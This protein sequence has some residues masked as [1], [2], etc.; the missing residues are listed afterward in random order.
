[1]FSLITKKVTKVRVL[2]FF[3]VLGFLVFVYS[4]RINCWLLPAARPAQNESA[5]DVV[6]IRQRNETKTVKVIRNETKTILVWNGSS[7]REV[8]N[9]GW[10]K[11]AFINKN[12]SY[13]RCEMTDNRLERPLEQFDAIIFVLNDEFTSPDQMMMPDFEKHKRNASQHIVMF[14]QEA[15][16][17]LK[18]YYNMTRLANFFNLSM[19][20]RMDSD[21]RLLYGR[22]IPKENAP[23][24]PEEISNL[25]EK[26][27]TIS[28]TPDSKR[29]KTKTVAWMVSHCNTPGQRETYVKELSKYIDVDIYGRCGN[30]SCALDVL[31]SS[32]PQCYDMIEST[33]KFYLSFENAICPGYVTEKFFKIMDHHIVPV[34]YGGANYTQCAPPHSYIDARKF[35]PKELAT[36]L[37]LLD[38][39]DTLY[40]EYFWWKDYYRVEYSE[41]DMTRHGFCDLCQKL[42]EAEDGDFE[43]Y[44]ELEAEWGN[45]NK[46]QPFDPSWIS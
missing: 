23:R 2:A 28:L 33:Y 1:M 30:L 38:A 20:Y 10:G 40:N 11:D 22:I 8:R 7:R 36:H 31:H 17:A 4:L 44:K 42:H 18:R 16:P 46:C 26:A 5:A 41:E 25:R 35:K 13:P 24:T 32:N 12:C 43:T 27:R 9:F 37:K 14:T 39:N 45:G 29:N 15:P 6:V 34:V 3:L 19:T 21:I